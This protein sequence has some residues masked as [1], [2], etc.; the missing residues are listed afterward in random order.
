M[1]RGDSNFSTWFH[2]V[3]VLLPRMQSADDKLVDNALNSTQVD[4]EVLKI[5]QIPPLLAKAKIF[6][7]W[8]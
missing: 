4:I 1:V 3:Q 2:I 6:L 5:L 7:M 8:H